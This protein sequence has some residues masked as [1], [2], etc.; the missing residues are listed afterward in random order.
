MLTLVNHFS[1]FCAKRDPGIDWSTI[2]QHEEGICDCLCSDYEDIEQ[3]NNV[4]QKSLEWLENKGYLKP[5]NIENA[6]NFP[7]QRYQLHWPII[8]EK[9]AVESPILL[10]PLSLKPLSLKEISQR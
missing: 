6:W 10:K 3:N 7:I 1:L 9:L 5:Y 4:K 8:K 2:T